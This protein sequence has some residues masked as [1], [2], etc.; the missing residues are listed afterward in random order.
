MGHDQL[1]KENPRLILL[2]IGK[3][4]FFGGVFSKQEIFPFSFSTSTYFIR[5]CLMF[6][7]HRSSA[8]ANHC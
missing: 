8:N 4:G 3:K 1:P 2:S 7:S 5:T 6:Y